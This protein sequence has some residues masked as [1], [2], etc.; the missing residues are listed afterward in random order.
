M[1]PEISFKVV[2]DETHYS[3]GCQTKIVGK[4]FF[5]KPCSPT[6][7][8]FQYALESSK[9]YGHEISVMEAEN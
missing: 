8:V 7:E 5:M 9:K 3:C 2:G 4:N 6:C 1:T